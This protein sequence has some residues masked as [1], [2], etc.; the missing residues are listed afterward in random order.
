MFVTMAFAVLD[1]EAKRVDYV[2]A[3]H[4]PVVWR[5]I[6]ARETRLL[7]GGGIG[8]GI[9]APALF[10]KTLTIETLDLAAGDALVFYSDGLTEA[11]NESLEEF[12]EERLIA[13]VERAD[14]MQAAAARDSILREVRQFLRGVHAQDDLTIAVLR[15]NPGPLA[16]QTETGR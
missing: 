6:S 8:L 3:G 11:M 15:V 5:R 16:R 9:A 12:G 10:N 13:A 4:N 1:P 2:R 14:G 7:R